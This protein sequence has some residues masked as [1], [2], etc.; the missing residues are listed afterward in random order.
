MSTWFGITKK[1][2]PKR[3]RWLHMQCVST[4]LVFCPTWDE[5]RWAIKPLVPPISSYLVCRF[6]STNPAASGAPFQLYCVPI[7]ALAH[8]RGQRHRHARLLCRIKPRVNI[9]DPSFLLKHFW[10]YHP[11]IASWSRNTS[12]FNV[13]TSR[14]AETTT[15]AHRETVEITCLVQ[16]S[17][18]SEISRVR[19]QVIS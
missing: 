17:F 14:A 9:P 7:H 5:H 11:A 3:V 2:L 19:G 4:G 1:E 6:V 13:T 8:V 12:T 16:N 18:I 15:E 10:G